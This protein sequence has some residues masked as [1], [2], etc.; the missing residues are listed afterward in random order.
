MKQTATAMCDSPLAP[1]LSSAARGESFETNPSAR[2]TIDFAKRTHSQNRTPMPQRRGHA[3]HGNSKGWLVGLLLFLA[4]ATASAQYEARVREGTAALDKNNL[5]QARASFED[6][7]RIAPA[8]PGGWLLLAET[9]ARDKDR[10]KA[11]AAAQKAEQ[12]GA[13]DPRILQGLA[14]FYATQVQDFPKA[15]SLGA[16]YAE[17]NPSDATA[18]QR[19]ASFCLQTG[20]RRKRWK[21]GSGRWR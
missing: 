7:T 16:R 2:G 17:K 9:Y 20:S 12:L 10:Q 11:L 18:W 14:N 5:A 21:P 6:A 15:A 13:D 3:R 1:V 4:S 19:L 8:Q